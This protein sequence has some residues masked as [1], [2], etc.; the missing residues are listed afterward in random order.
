[1]ESTDLLEALGDL[2]PKYV[3][4]AQAMTAW[5]LGGGIFMVLI[6]I[7]AMSVAARNLRKHSDSDGYSLWFLVGIGA[8]LVVLLGSIL[9]IRYAMRL[10]HPEAYALERLVG[11]QP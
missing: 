9:T 3:E 7:V 1:M 5:G 10:G 8:S 2:A 11:Q 4:Y 6:G